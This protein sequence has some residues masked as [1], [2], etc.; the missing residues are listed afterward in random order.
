MTSWFMAKVN[1]ELGGKA[2]GGVIIRLKLGEPFYSGSDATLTTI[3]NNTGITL[4]TASPEIEV[5]TVQ[6]ICVT[7]ELTG[8][9]PCGFGRVVVVGRLR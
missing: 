8:V 4:A 5:L 1:C 9:S 2:S 7:N 3:D 6:I